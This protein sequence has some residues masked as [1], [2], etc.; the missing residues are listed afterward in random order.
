M[1][2]NKSTRE[3]VVRIVNNELGGRLNPKI[4]LLLTTRT[5]RRLRRSPDAY[6]LRPK[7]SIRAALWREVWEL[8]L[9]PFILR[10]PVN[11]A[12]ARRD[13]GVS[14]ASDAPQPP[15]NAEFFLHLLLKE[16]EQEA[17]IGCLVER[18]VR[19]VGRLGKRR[20]DVWFY[21]EVA[22]SIWPLARRFASKAIRLAVLG[23]WIRRMI[24]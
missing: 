10:E 2:I 19:K 21:A 18:Y 1:E 17:F 12:A 8:D 5:L 15:V 16:E 22:R 13:A 11:V 24:Q 9:N 7:A 14:Q 3:L 20:A 6:P 4:L 23:E